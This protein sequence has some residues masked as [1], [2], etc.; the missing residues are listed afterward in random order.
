MPHSAIGKKK[1]ASFFLAV[2][3]NT[4]VY[5]MALELPLLNGKGM[6]SDKKLLNRVHA[7]SEGCF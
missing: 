1:Y 6:H 3:L 7:A 5:C 2:I 4:F